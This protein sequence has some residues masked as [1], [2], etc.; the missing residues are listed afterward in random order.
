MSDEVQ[1]LDAS[2]G[3]EL[4]IVEGEGRAHAIIWPGMGA[5]LR[6][7]Q[8]ISLAGGA[9]MKEL[10]HPGEAVYYVIE[11]TGETHDPET[12][13]SQ[14]LIE[15]SMVHV[16]PETSY[17]IRAGDDGMELVGGPSPPDPALYEGVEG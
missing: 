7:M 9:A 10:R 3:P 6:S 17:V 4:P 13:E 8:R 1:V 5:E 15:G 14:A 11:G 2:V 12:G 16:E